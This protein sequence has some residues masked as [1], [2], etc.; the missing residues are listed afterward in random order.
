MKSIS[1]SVGTF[2]AWTHLIELFVSSNNYSLS[3][4]SNQLYHDVKWL[5]ADDSKSNIFF[6]KVN[7]K[8]GLSQADSD[9]IR[10]IQAEQIFKSKIFGSWRLLGVYFRNFLLSDSVKWCLDVPITLSRCLF[11]GMNPHILFAKLQVSVT[12]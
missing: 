10:R 11:L 2:M 3:S 8:L 5:F 9:Q 4:V 1:A 6:G 7:G 12:I